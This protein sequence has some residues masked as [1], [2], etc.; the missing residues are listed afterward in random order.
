MQTI[1]IPEYLN[2]RTTH[3]QRQAKQNKRK[4]KVRE[5]IKILPIVIVLLAILAIAG[6][7]DQQALSMGIIH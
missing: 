2:N 6:Y 3:K 5:I 7:Y 1:N 4:R